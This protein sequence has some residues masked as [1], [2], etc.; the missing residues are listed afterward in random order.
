MPCGHV[1]AKT[2]E[3]FSWLSI[4]ASLLVSSLGEAQGRLN[5]GLGGGGEVSLFPL[6][7]KGIYGTSFLSLKERNRLSFRK[8]F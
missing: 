1:E 6:H 4:S 2:E 8:V 7:E 3:M 5:E